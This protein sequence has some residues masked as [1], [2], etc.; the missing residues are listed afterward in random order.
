MI[1]GAESEP[2][3]LEAVMTIIIVLAAILIG[4]AILIELETGKPAKVVIS[5]WWNS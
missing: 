3:T 1:Y 2:T 4:T 5:Q